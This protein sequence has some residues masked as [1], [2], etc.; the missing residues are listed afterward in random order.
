VNS[1]AIYKGV[2]YSFICNLYWWYWWF[3]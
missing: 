1:L 2:L 3:D